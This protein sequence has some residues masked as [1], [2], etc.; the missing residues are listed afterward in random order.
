[1]EPK[2][3]E[4]LQEGDIVFAYTE[5]KLDIDQLTVIERSGTKEY[6]WIHLSD[7][8]AIRCGKEDIEEYKRT[9]RY[10]CYTGPDYSYPT[11]IF[12]T[13]EAAVQDRKK[14]MSNGIKEMQ[15]TLQEYFK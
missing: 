9:G 12:L 2:N 14:F 7:D 8:I 15:Q 11:H 1:M 5:D 4:D 3:F 13:E 6:S 10:T